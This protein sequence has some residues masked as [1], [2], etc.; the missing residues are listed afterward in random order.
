MKKVC[1]WLFALLVTSAV[2]CVSFFMPDIFSELQQKN[3]VFE[4]ESYETEQMT[5]ETNYTSSDLFK[6]ARNIGS[7]VLLD[8]GKNMTRAEAEKTALSF[9]CSIG[10]CKTNNAVPI[11]VM[12]DDKSQSCIMWS[13]SGLINGLNSCVII[14]DSTKRILAVNCGLLKESESTP[15]PR[16]SEYVDMES[17]EQEEKFDGLY[18]EVVTS[19]Q[20]FGIY[21]DLTFSGTK[22]QSPDDMNCVLCYTDADGASIELNAQWQCEPSGLG[23]AINSWLL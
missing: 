17:S 7:G 8:E 22:F 15:L 4:T 12:S 1:V 11:L 2:I 10:D 20:M 14:D 23:I 19:A 9:V 16:E 13:W 3:D 18:D 6:L 21:S 5:Y